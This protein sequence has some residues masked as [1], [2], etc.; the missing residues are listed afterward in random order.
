MFSPRREVLG[1]RRDLPGQ[2]CNAMVLGNRPRMICGA[3]GG[4]SQNVHTR[5]R[6]CARRK[7][8]G[9]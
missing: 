7:T 2:N 6:F 3:F 8:G 1:D 9:G 4:V 5:A